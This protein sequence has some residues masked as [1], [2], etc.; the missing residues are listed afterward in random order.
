MNAD[1]Y[2]WLVDVQRADEVRRFVVVGASV[3]EAARHAQEA[4]AA[5][6]GAESRLV[7]IELLAPALLGAVAVE[8]ASPPPQVNES[9][10]SAPAGM[11]RGEQLVGFLRDRGGRAHLHEIAEGLSTSLANAQNVI[12]AAVK[13]GLAEREG[14]RTGIV[15]LVDA[16]MEPTPTRAPPVPARSAARPSRAEQVVEVLR[17]HGG[18]VHASVIAEELSTDALNARNCVASAVKSGLAERVGNRSGRVRLVEEAPAEVTPKGPAATVPNPE[19]LTGI[20]RR[21]YDAMAELGAPATA[22]EIA[23]MLGCRP[24]E[25]GNAATL[26]AV[27]GLTVKSRGPMRSEYALTRETPRLH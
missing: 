6:E 13:K 15:V 14:Q 21:V 1:L 17:R 19:E 3:V 18:E 23:E 2:A 10:L 11:S 20:L 26:L 22:Q 7:G 12:A 4:I 27:R 8:A 25:A 9:Q 16:P 24:R 5:A